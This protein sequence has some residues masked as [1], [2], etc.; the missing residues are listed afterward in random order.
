MRYTWSYRW[1]SSQS[2][3]VGVRAKPDISH[4]HC[5]RGVT[6]ISGGSGETRSLVFKKLQSSVRPEVLEA[7]M[8]G[9]EGVSELSWIIKFD[10]V[11]PALVYIQM[12]GHMGA[13]PWF[14]LHS[15]KKTNSCN[16]Y[17]V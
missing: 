5:E 2:D 7:L 10:K 3:R 14:L 1:Y 16:P 4:C 8:D 11:S 17:I 9:G 12:F 15:G 13:G 6:S